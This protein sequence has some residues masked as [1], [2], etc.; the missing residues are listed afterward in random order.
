[1]SRKRVS[2][3]ERFWSKVNKNGPVVADALGPCWVWTAGLNVWGYGKFWKDGAT[4]GAHRISWTL[5]HGPVLHR[6][7]EGGTCVLH[8]CDNPACVNPAHLFLGTVAQ[9]NADA[10][11][12]GRT[13]KGDKNGS[14][15]YPERRPRGDASPA[16]R[17]PEC[18]ARGDRNGSRLHPERRPRGDANFARRCRE[19]MPRGEDNGRAVLT[20]ADVVEIRRRAAAGEGAVR[21]SA[22][23]GVSKSNVQ[24]IVARKT[25]RHVA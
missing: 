16:R 10:K 4:I 14:R 19:Q 2:D 12:K 15:R 9:N 3:E 7:G 17:R 8:R 22:A 18:L 24:F 11:A 20:A 23:F 13:A 25:W 21:L 1:M 5:A 6:G